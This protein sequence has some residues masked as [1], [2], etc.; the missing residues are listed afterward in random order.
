[1]KGNRLLKDIPLKTTSLNGV[2]A[3]GTLR[4]IH[5][6]AK[7]QRKFH[8]P[9]YIRIFLKYTCNCHIY[10]QTLICCATRKFLQLLFL[11]HSLYL[12]FILPI[13]DSIIRHVNE[14][15][16]FNLS[17]HCY[18]DCYI[19]I[20]LYSHFCQLLSNN[21]QLRGIPWRHPLKHSCT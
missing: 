9:Q 21:I 7:R 5:R 20:L 1:M 8:S 18:M 15:N 10:H 19:A 3:K 17:N 13:V 6:S 12:L 14:L 16:N 2:R 4:T 11:S